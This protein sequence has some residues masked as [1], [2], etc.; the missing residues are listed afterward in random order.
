MPSTQ[1]R[2]YQEDFA[3]GMVKDA[4]PHLIPDNGVFDIQNGLLS[5]DGSIF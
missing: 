3:A 5:D 4:A 1:E 2:T